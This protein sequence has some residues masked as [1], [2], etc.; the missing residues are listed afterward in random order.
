MGKKATGKNG[1]HPGGRPTKYREEY[2]DLAYKFCL[3]GGATDEKLAKLFEVTESTISKWKLDHPKFSES[4]KDGKERADA[5]IVKALFHRAKGYQ[6]PEDKIFLHE[7]EPVIVP[8]VKHYPPDTGAA[9]MWLK[10]RAGW[11]DKVDHEISGTVEH[12]IVTFGSP[13]SDGG[14]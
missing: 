14:G 8:T 3:L 4:L 2:C 9:C 6:H 13:D 11:R 1:K 12:R 7:G 10:N 5:E